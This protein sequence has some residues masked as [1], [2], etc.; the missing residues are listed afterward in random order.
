MTRNYPKAISAR[1]TRDA[2]RQCSTSGSGA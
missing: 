2:G 1:R